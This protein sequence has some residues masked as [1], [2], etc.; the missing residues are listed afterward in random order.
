MSF[1]PS[2]PYLVV[3]G[4][5]ASSMAWRGATAWEKVS[6]AVGLHELR[7]ALASPASSSAAEPHASTDSVL[8]E[9]GL[10][11]DRWREGRDRA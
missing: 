11:L 1:P 2:L 10:A 9:A 3:G 6:G 7:N 4:L 5:D 8:I